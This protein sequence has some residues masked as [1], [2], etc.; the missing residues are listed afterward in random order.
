LVVVSSDHPY[1][2]QFGGGYG[3]GHI[4]MMIKLPHQSAPVVYSHRF[5]AVNTRNLIEDFMQGR[6]AT[7]ERALAWLDRSGPAH[8][9]EFKK[10]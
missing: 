9:V 3:N 8:S 2:Y 6:F 5:E 4:P 10:Q 7:P 1:R